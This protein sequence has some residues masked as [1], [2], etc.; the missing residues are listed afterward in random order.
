MSNV[1]DELIAMMKSLPKPQPQGDPRTLNAYRHG[2]TG[3][4]RF[5][6]P[7]DEKSYKRHWLGY[8]ECY[9]PAGRL[10]TDLCQAVAD[11]RWR[12]KNAAQIENA[13]VAITLGQPDQMKCDNEEAAIAF[14]HAYAWLERGK[15]LNLLTLYERR[16]QRA[17]QDDL[18]LLEKLQE[19]RFRS[20]YARAQQAA[21]QAA[22][23][24]QAAEKAASEEAAA[25]EAEERS[26]TRSPRRL[27]PKCV[28]STRPSGRSIPGKH[29]RMPLSSPTLDEI[30][31]A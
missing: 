14:A 10:E 25:E 4:V 5:S 8:L 16:I 9:E 30:L 3:H 13:I 11:N 29:P 31:A 23:A 18:A 22:A 15:D 28:F 21:A 24:Q 12:L 19:R 26:Q 1:T 7:A 2:L 6:T 20:E 27:E 17:F